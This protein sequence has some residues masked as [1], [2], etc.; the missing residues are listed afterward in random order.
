MSIVTIHDLFCDGD[1]C[2]RMF[3]FLVT[4]D[5][6]RSDV[7]KR[8]ARAGWSRPTIG[9]KRKDLCRTCTR[10]RENP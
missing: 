7:R 8:A 3:E 1:G 10:K 6:T 2:H 4:D 9:R 5:K